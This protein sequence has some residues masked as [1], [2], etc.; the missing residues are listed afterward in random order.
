MTQSEQRGGAGELATA[1]RRTIGFHRLIQYA[2]NIPVKPVPDCH[3]VAVQVGCFGY[4][5][6]AAA[7]HLKH[8]RTA[9]FFHA[10]AVPFK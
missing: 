9:L 8:P 6:T 2:I 4:A 3:D 5:M 10:S 7:A 1:T